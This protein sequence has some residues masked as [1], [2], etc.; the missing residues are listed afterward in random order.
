MS[1]IVE[2]EQAQ[3]DGLTVAPYE[4]GYV[5]ELAIAGI[6]ACNTLQE[7]SMAL[8]DRLAQSADTEMQT[9][10]DKLEGL[11][12]TLKGKSDNALGKLTEARR[13]SEQLLESAAADAL[14]SL[15]DQRVRL[16]RQ[17]ETAALDMIQAI[18]GARQDAA[19]AATAHVQTLKELQK[20]RNQALLAKYGIQ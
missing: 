2:Y 16:V 14:S 6:D 13:E 7:I 20:Q 11:A 12:E 9:I 19:Q 5:E 8:Q 3:E 15:G 1:E 4:S 18:D 10:A 17:V